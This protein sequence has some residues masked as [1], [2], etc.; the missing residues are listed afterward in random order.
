MSSGIQ[1]EKSPKQNHQLINSQLVNQNRLSVPSMAQLLTPAQII[2]SNHFQ[3]SIQGQQTQNFIKTTAGTQTLNLVGVQN[4]QYL[5]TPQQQYQQ[6]NQMQNRTQVLNK[7]FVTTET[8]TLNSFEVQNQQFGTNSVINNLNAIL[9][10]LLNISNIDHKD[11]EIP[12][13]NRN[14]ICDGGRWVAYNGKNRKNEL[15]TIKQSNK[16]STDKERLENE[17]INEM[18]VLTSYKHDNILPLLGYCVGEE[19]LYLTY[20]YQV[21]GSVGNNINRPNIERRKKFD[22]FKRIDVAIAVSS[23]LSYLHSNGVVHKDLNTD[24]IL[25]NENFHPKLYN[26]G[27]S[28]SMGYLKNNYDNQNVKIDDDI[29]AFGVILLQ[30][31]V[32]M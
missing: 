9:M 7:V 32:S 25:L 14:I 13:N 17:F 8:Q 31:L 23:A 22:C 16:L 4:Q 20:P 3:T 2:N 27:T 28:G 21:N 30:L 26:F 6:I 24:N 19:N 15:M 1:P 10:K 29:F 18:K 5:P 12:V 11:I